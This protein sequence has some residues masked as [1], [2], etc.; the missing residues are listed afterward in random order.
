MNN[1]QVKYSVYF[2]AGASGRFIMTI[3]DGLLRDPIEIKYTHNSAHDFQSCNPNRFY[4]FVEG[5]A[6]W[7]DF[8]KN[9]SPDTKYIIISYNSSLLKE[10]ARNMMYKNIIY[11]VQNIEKKRKNLK[12]YLNNKNIDYSN[13]DIERYENNALKIFRDLYQE[14]TGIKWVKNSTDD[15]TVDEQQAME[16]QMYEWMLNDP[17]VNAFLDPIQITAKNLL[18][19]EYGDIFRATGSDSWIALDQ[20]VKYAQVKDVNPIVLSNYR[21]YVSQRNQAVEHHEQVSI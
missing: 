19:I 13:W 8:P 12:N 5:I 6:T 9:F 16:E 15:L 14:A 4:Y 20:L 7:H 1:Q 17:K 11:N 18:V 2:P 10:I 21:Q 3:L